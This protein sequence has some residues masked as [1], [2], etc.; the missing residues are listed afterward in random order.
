MY[1]TFLN[2]KSLWNQRFHR[3]FTFKED[4]KEIKE[5]FTFKEFKE[6]KED[7]KEIK[8]DFTFTQSS[9]HWKNRRLEK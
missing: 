5:D 6:I 7:F 9:V 8:E 4:F 2:V 1:A 3:D